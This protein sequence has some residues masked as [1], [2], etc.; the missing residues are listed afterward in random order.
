MATSL[1]R[2]LGHGMSGGLERLLG[3]GMSGGLVSPQ[4]PEM[5]CVRLAKLT[6]VSRDSGPLCLRIWSMRGED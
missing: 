6:R 2:L 1:E 4:S 3:H 5:L